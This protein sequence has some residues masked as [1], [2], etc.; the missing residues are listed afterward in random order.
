ML[1]SSYRYHISYKAGKLHANAD[2]LSRLPVQECQKSEDE[3]QGKEVLMLETLPSGG[4]PLSAKVKEEHTDKD[5]VLARVKGMIL[6]GKW[7]S[8]GSKQA[9]MEPYLGPGTQSGRRMH[10]LG[11]SSDCT[12]QA[13]TRI[14]WPGVDKDIDNKVKAFSHLS[15]RHDARPE[16]ECRLRNTTSSQMIA[17]KPHGRGTA[18]V[19]NCGSGSTATIPTQ[20]EATPPT[21]ENEERDE[22]M[23]EMA[24]GNEEDHAEQGGTEEATMVEKPITPPQPEV[25]L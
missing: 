13:A 10:P 17:H 15:V 24:V 23:S 12:H 1:L 6:L 4:K 19:T 5:E 25:V 11:K 21:G 14:W 22:N 3:V 8:K 18:V 16:R 20:S 2:C 7:D 9:D